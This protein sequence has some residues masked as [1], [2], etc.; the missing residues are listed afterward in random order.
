MN[1]GKP[2][3]KTLLATWVELVIVNKFCSPS[4]TLYFQQAHTDNAKQ[5]RLI[6][7]LHKLKGKLFAECTVTLLLPSSKVQF[8]NTSL[9]CAHEVDSAFARMSHCLT[10]RAELIG[11]YCFLLRSIV[12]QMLGMSEST[13]GWQE[14]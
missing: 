1:K 10:G 12:S 5:E 9:C 2:A 13:A 14:R 4:Q 11:C 6:H 8:P 3:T 7:S